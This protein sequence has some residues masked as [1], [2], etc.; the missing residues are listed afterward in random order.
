MC[1]HNGKIVGACDVACED[2]HMISTNP[3]RLKKTCDPGKIEDLKQAIEKMERERFEQEQQKAQQPV[4][5]V[6]FNPTASEL[7]PQRG[8]YS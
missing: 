5:L 6:F 3:H 1:P 4:Q 7:F 8:L 2:G